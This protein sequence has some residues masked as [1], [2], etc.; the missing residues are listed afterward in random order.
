[1]RIKPVKKNV[2]TLKK[3]RKRYVTKRGYQLKRDSGRYIGGVAALKKILFY[4]SLPLLR[5]LVISC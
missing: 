1:L 5:S 4:F 2:K 3:K